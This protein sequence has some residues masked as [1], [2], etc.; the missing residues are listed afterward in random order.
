MLKN[1]QQIGH[2]KILSAIGAGGMGEVFLAEDTQLKRK[3]ALKILSTAF[4]QDKERLHRFEQEACAASALN[5]PN[6]LTIH[7]F[8]SERGVSFIA[9][10]FIKGETLRERMRQE[11]LS[12]GEALD[13][14]IQI[15]AALNV[16]HEAGI[17]HRDIKPENIM[18]RD[19]GLVKV[20][21]FGLAKL[22]EKK[23]EPVESEDATRAQV[24]TSPGVVMGTVNYMSP[25]QARG[26]AVDARSDIWSL[27]IVLY[28]MLSQRTPFAEETM[29]DTIA[30]ILKGELAPLEETFPTELRR[31]IRKALQKKTDERYQT[32][33]DFLLD[34]KNLK[35]ELEFSEEIERSHIPA[36]A[37]SANVSANQSGESATAIHPAGISTQNSIAQQTVNSENNVSQ[38]T[39]SA[40]Y[41][42]GEVKKHKFISLGALAAVVLLLLIGG[43]FTFFSKRATAFD[44]V[45]VLPFA[46]ASGNQ[47][48]EFLSDGISETLINNF[49]KIPSLRVTA[50]S[51]AFRYKGKE[52]DP[53]TIGKELNVG[54][55]LTGKVL[56]RGDALSVQVD[57]INAAD[58]TQIW[59]NQYNG[60]ASEILN[61]Q[62]SIARDV[63]E[64]LKLKLS[65]AQEQR[66]VKNYTANPEA[67]QLYLKGR[68]Y[69][70]RRTGDNLKKAIEQFKAAAEKDPNYALAYAGLADCYAVLEQY[71]GTP[72][73]E[74]LPQARSYAERALA[75]DEQLAEAHATL[76]V[77]NMGLWQWTEAEKEF[78]RA[79]EL[80]P[81]YA[82][83]H[84]WYH[85]YLHN[86]GRQDE[87]F[88]EIKRAQEL[89]P[90]S[91]VINSNVSLAYVTRNDPNSALE[92]SRKYLEIDPNDDGSY[93]A[94]GSAYLKLGR[95]AE[96]LA[97]LEKAVELSG[98]DSNTLGDLGYAYAVAG[99]RAEALAVIKELE[100]RYARREAIGQ[101]LAQVYA[102]LGEKDEA[103]KW[104]EKDFQARS[105]SLPFV[106]WLFTFDALR[107]DAR[108]ADLLQRMNLPQ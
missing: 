43:Y 23:V 83:A 95:N 36:F 31:I 97:A 11:A 68:F 42:V 78:K 61:V 86:V 28:E 65:G 18:L 62:Q 88:T 21:D 81:N 100:G 75:I 14:A 91:A 41:I 38:Q 39:S 56:Q 6:I 96:A 44:S 51:T 27:G 50:R 45:A 3:V 16:A 57:L 2:Y 71:A 101:S 46:N 90:L 4:N 93:Q 17:V 108:Y 104:L 85:L 64:Q 84:G 5:H 9:T 82:T 35:R 48:T 29:N 94:M 80:N 13:V 10:E 66:M 99:N 53:Q 79:I 70:N 1:G 19:D 92:N 47:E 40:E 26:K 24:N 15:A 77:I 89:E 98:G 34:L 7:E 20:L 105:Q 74:T 63:S 54:A 106:R 59:G 76:G 102:G 32:V 67:Y 87:A 103:F 72:A 33:K 55:I 60:K 69:W 22:T 49:T 30:A 58:G 73:S 8:S 12:L 37:K 107:S 52:T 25:E